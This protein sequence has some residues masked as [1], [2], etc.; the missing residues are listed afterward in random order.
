MNDPFKRVT[1]VIEYSPR[2]KKVFVRAVLEYKQH[3]QP[4]EPGNVMNHV[5][6]HLGDDMGYWVGISP[7]VPEKPK[8]KKR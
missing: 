3:L 8:R 7:L 6:V 4:L 2:L 5:D 1:A